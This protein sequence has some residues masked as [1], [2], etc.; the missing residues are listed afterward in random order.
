MDKAKIIPIVFLI[1]VLL[2]GGVAVMFYSENAKLAVANKK[3]VREKGDL[4]A[5]RGSLRD[6]N[7]RYEREKQSY[8]ERIQSI[9][10]QLTSIEKERDEWKKK[11]E[12]IS[13]EREALVEKLKEKPKVEV[14][15]QSAV[16]ATSSASAVSDEYWADFVKVKAALEVKVE[17]LTKQLNETKLQLSTMEKNNKELSL[18]IDELSQE[19]SRIEK[20]MEIKERTMR[21]VSRDLVSEREARKIAMEELSKLR[22][23][24]AS[25]KRELIVLNKEKVR[26][27]TNIMDVSAKKDDLQQKISNVEDVMKEKSLDLEE[28]Q[29]ELTTT[30]KGDSGVTAR[31]TASVELPPIVVKSGTS[32]KGLRGEILAVN[33]EEKF[34]VINIGEA[35]GIGP[36]NEFRVL[37]NNKEIGRVQ[38]IET[39]KDIC[40]ADIK[41]VAPGNML[42][43]GDI[44]ITR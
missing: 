27:Q 12:D 31:E 21:I 40:A 23:E 26:L 6:A 8:E 3:L 22:G 11:F 35:S 5:E 16:P 2:L 20:E 17:D 29:K 44:V 7:N 4:A 32:P 30:I 41:D 13:R 34:V 39:R 24:N 36:G 15:Q 1:I 33:P 42:R 38:V 37:R 19:K 18:K 25:L 10:S 28:L 14:V 43:E 9:S